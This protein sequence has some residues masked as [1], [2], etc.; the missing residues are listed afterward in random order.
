MDQN[1]TN[2]F[3][4]NPLSVTSSTVIH[5]CI[6]LMR[7]NSISSLVVCDNNKPVGIYT[8]A[9]MV[10]TLNKDIDYQTVQISELMSYPV[11]SAP[12]SINV[13]EATYI[14]TSNT[15]RH[16]VVT[17]SDGYL[18]GIL[19]QTDIIAHYGED[20]FIG[21]KSVGN[22][23]TKKILTVGIHENVHDVVNQ[24]EHY[25]SGCAIAIENGTPV[26]ILTERDM[27][28]LIV[29]G[30][31]IDGLM[32]KEVMKSPVITVYA[33]TSTFEAVSIMNKHKV[34]RILVIDEEVN[35]V[36][37]LIQEDI[38]R[39]LESNYVAFLKEVLSER[40]KK[41]TQTQQKFKARNSHL[42]NL[43]NSPLNIS[44]IVTD[45]RFN[46][47]YINQDSCKVFQ[48]EKSE[49]IKRPIDQLFKSD[50]IHE[51]SLQKIRDE[52]A[53]KGEYWFIH[54]RNINQCI[55]HIESRLT[56][57]I[58]NEKLTG[59]TL[60]S[61]DITDKLH[62]EKRLLLATHVFEC[63]IEGIMVTD[64]AGT[65]Q[66]VNPAFTD[67]TGY[68]A[69][70]AI[71][72]NPRM[73]QSN[74][75]P[76]E[77]YHDMWETIINTGRWQGEIW[78]R[79]KNGEVYP[80]RL[81]ISSVKDLNGK[82]IQYTSVFYDITDIKEKEEKINHRAYHDPLTELPNRLLFKDRLEQAI[83]RAKRNGN[84]LS[85]MF[86]DIDNFKRL[87]DTQGHH[88]GD[89]FLQQISINLRNLL[90]D[91]DTVSRFAGDEFTI[92]LDD[93]NSVE[94][95]VIVAQKILGLFDKPLQINSTEVYLG[96]SIG[97]A[98]YPSDGNNADTLLKNADTAMYH[99][100]ESGRNC[101]QIFE[102]AMETR[103]KQRLTLETELRK[104]LDNNQLH[105]H[106]Q[107]IINLRNQSIT[108]IE[109][110]LRW[111]NADSSIP[112]KDFIPIAEDSGLIIPIG[113]WVLRQTCQQMS[114]WK[115]DNVTDIAVSVNLSA[116][117][118][119][120]KDL[121]TTI[122]RILEETKLKP[123]QLHLEITES[124]VMDDMGNSV[125]TLNSLKKLGIRILL[126]DFGTGYSSLTCLKQFPVDVLKLDHTFIQNIDQD[127]DTARLAAGIISMAKDM[128]LDVVAEGVENETQLEFLK[129]HG[130]DMVQG[131]LFHRP[132]TEENL[133]EV[134][135]L[136]QARK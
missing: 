115:I 51:Q 29:N 132:L 4:P 21:A 111:D 15:I 102:T 100:K 38:I 83:T 20:Y 107:P 73:L 18:A 68:P 110:L 58:E 80:Q 82:V 62:T 37:I 112:P 104:A 91:Q 134:L 6:T 22:V 60:V 133:K 46:I 70:E 124:S 10:R 74:R 103:I 108:S 118:F 117:Q 56:P 79:R 24:M 78:N 57:I 72:N 28:T 33:S 14:L 13:F 42:E 106:Y 123:E 43:L 109:A 93:N 48:V 66:L 135:H 17:D 69:A 125:A 45:L 99:A 127:A 94:H 36:G 50:S 54:L 113:E 11:I 3:T 8:E 67:I 97:I 32:M 77:F 39:N 34:R 130:C 95:A 1:I 40:N 122:E 27:A 5:D 65:I 121:L 81:A 31:E 55:H 126:D 75:Q 35:I 63:A 53:E 41:L 90:R 114:T 129:E 71:G 116:R 2:I 9:D 88:V 84:S 25:T 19:T 16:L 119:R 26:G 98:C 136:Q 47:V 59:Y 120:E 49:F 23:M 89:Q 96:A 92:L 44:I 76:P 86:I 131:Y 52:V 128:R 101:F 7:K 61:Q 105:I 87:N 85:I 30:T 12:S 64:T